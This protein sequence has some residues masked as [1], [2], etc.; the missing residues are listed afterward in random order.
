MHFLESINFPINQCKHVEH[1][2]CIYFIYLVL[3]MLIVLVLDRLK[4]D[5]VPYFFQALFLTL[6]VAENDLCRS[7]TLQL[8]YVCVSA[9]R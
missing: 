9:R 8:I 2:V 3:S 6:V 1:C 7:N 4:N 5:F